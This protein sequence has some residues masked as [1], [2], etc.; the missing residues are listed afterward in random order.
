MEN[1]HIRTRLMFFLLGLVLV[2]FGNALSIIS[3]AGNGLWTAAALGM[4]QWSGVSISFILMMIALIVIGINLLLSGRFSWVTVSGELLFVLLFS[5]LIHFFVTALSK[6]FTVPVDLWLRIFLA[7]VGITIVCLGTSFYQRANLWM[8][9]TDSLT[10]LLTR[11][12]FHHHFAW[13][14]LVAFV[15]PVILITATTFHLHAVVG[16]QVGTLFSLACNGSLIAF[17]NKRVFPFLR[18]N[19]PL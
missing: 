3:T 7:I 2:A 6:N 14:Q 4:A 1:N 17:F 19:S 18:L 16:V 15:P 13:A 5:Q 8:Y 9:P 10:T 12:F 11:R